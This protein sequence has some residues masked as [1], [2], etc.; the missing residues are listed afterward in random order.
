MIVICFS[1][2]GN[3]YAQ[4][5]EYTSNNIKL[6]IPQK[7]IIGEEYQGVVTLLY[8]AQ[9]SSLILLS[10]DDDFVLDVDTSVNIQTNKNHGTFNITPLNEGDATIS[11]LYDGEIL[12]ADTKVYSKKSDAQKLK[13]VLPT[14]STITTDMKGMVFLLDGN[15]S[16]IQ[17]TFD[18]IISLVTSEKIFTPNHITIQNGSS[19]AIFDVIVYATGEI[20]AI[21]PQL[22]SYTIPIEKSQQIIDVKLGIVLQLLSLIPHQLLQSQD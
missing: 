14:N 20:T 18:R 22:E 13:V 7:M 3:S 4:S 11:I 15:D 5:E 12:S 21:A 16:P 19:Y 17:S 2:L 1:H 8:P 10:V 6:F 9:S